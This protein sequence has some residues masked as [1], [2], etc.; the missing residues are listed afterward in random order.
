MQINTMGDFS[1]MKFVLDGV[2]YLSA[3]RDAVAGPELGWIV[4]IIAF[5]TFTF[6]LFQAATKKQFW[7]PIIFLL[8]GPIL[9]NMAV[10]TTEPVTAG[11]AKGDVQ[12]AQQIA[13]AEATIF[14]AER[15]MAAGGEAK[16]IAASD[17]AIAQRKLVAFREIERSQTVSV[18]EV[19]VLFASIYTI[20]Q[21]AGSAVWNVLSKVQPMEM[22]SRKYQAAIAHDL[23]LNLALSPIEQQVMRQLNKC[24]AAKTNFAGRLEDLTAGEYRMPE[25]TGPSVTSAEWPAY[26]EMWKNRVI[27]GVDFHRNYTEKMCSGL[28]AEMTSAI[29]ASISQSEI[30]LYQNVTVA[31]SWLPGIGGKKY[32]GTDAPEMQ[33]WLASQMGIDAD[34]VK[35]MSP[36]KLSKMYL[37]YKHIQAIAER[38]SDDAES[39]ADESRLSFI[40]PGQQPSESAKGVMGGMMTSFL[41]EFAISAK[42]WIFRG[43]NYIWLFAMIAYVPAML[44][45]MTPGNHLRVPLGY[46][47]FLLFMAM[48]QVTVNV[49]E[50]NA[51]SRESER[52]GLAA[53]TTSHVDKLGAI[54][55]NVWNNLKSSASDLVLGGAAASQSSAA[56][57]AIRQGLAQGLRSPAAIPVAVTTALTLGISSV[58]EE[59]QMMSEEQKE[60]GLLLE[61]TGKLSPLLMA[62]ANGAVSAQRQVIQQS[63][64]KSLGMEALL[65]IIS[66]IATTLLF[67]GGFQAVAALNVGG[68]AAAAGQALGNTFAGMGVSRL[69]GGSKGS[70]T[71]GG[72][73][74]TGGGSASSTQS[75][76]RE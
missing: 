17:L 21:A 30:D 37:R 76:I 68:Q 52:V 5:L 67:F 72:K 63:R 53:A 69:A 20:T 22:N 1:Q 6:Y 45:A 56:R 38:L 9:L 10:F 75:A 19:P 43:M 58:S 24:L 64:D 44:L 47:S 8:M 51:A 71:G 57:A 36:E 33:E 40:E 49:I 26:E 70:P 11:T 66:P 31:P 65:L 41:L 4:L 35:K 14:S 42:P 46:L 23:S 32:G 39:A 54:G 3:M 2:A 7:P 61:G 55:G 16:L 50:A 27:D 48:W 34:E 73:V 18:G 29:D 28:D 25:Y 12:L 62:A 59:W 60:L 74:P 15:Q 13:S